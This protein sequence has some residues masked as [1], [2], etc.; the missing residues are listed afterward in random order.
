MFFIVLLRSEVRRRAWTGS[1]P[2][3]VAGGYVVDTLESRDD[4]QTPTDRNQILD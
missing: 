4:Q 2:P 1:V 3:A